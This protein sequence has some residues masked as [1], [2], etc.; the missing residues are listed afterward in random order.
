MLGRDMRGLPRRVD[1]QVAGPR[2]VRAGGELA[3]QQ[4][5]LDRGSTASPCR[6][7]GVSPGARTWSGVPLGNAARSILATS[8]ALDGSSGCRSA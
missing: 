8:R 5:E 4:F 7:Y 6:K 1:L 2:R 3:E